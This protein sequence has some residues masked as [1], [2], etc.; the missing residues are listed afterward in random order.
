MVNIRVMHRV[1][2]DRSDSATLVLFI[3]YSGFRLRSSN[4]LS[5]EA[6]VEFAEAF[7]LSI[8]RWRAAGQWAIPVLPSMQAEAP[9]HPE[10]MLYGCTGTLLGIGTLRDKIE[11]GR[12]Q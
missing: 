6:M 9:A 4:P 2:L 8:N 1:S 5:G 3:W 7:N 10:S 12:S 11:K